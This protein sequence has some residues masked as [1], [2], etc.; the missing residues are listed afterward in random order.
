MCLVCSDP[1]SCPQ[2]CPDCKGSKVYVG[3]RGSEPC[4]L[5]QGQGCLCPLPSQPSGVSSTPKPSDPIIVSGDVF[6]AFLKY[7]KG[8]LDLRYQVVD[9]ENWKGG[10]TVPENFYGRIRSYFK[11][12]H[13]N[14]T[15]VKMMLDQVVDELSLNCWR[16]AE[17]YGPVIEQLFI[18]DIEIEPVIHS[19]MGN[20]CTLSYKTVGSWQK[21]GRNYER[22]T[23]C[24][25]GCTRTEIRRMW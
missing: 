2:V 10:L 12:I 4:R 14:L 22:I 19:P 15:G 23:S 16:C 8:E 25:N 7:F 18:T 11:A 13:G 9:I 17:G 1:K 24:I 5:C 20:D 21:M 6:G 3:L